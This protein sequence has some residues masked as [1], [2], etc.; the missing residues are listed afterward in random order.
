M[1]T[2]I[3]SKVTHLQLTMGKEEKVRIVVNVDHVLHYRECNGGTFIEQTRGTFVQ[4]NES[5]DVI[6]K[7]LN[8]GKE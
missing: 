5:L 1:W 7:A 6:I 4:V 3:S 8:G 2:T